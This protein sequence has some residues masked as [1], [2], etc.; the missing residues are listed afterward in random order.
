MA[1]V[2][3]KPGLY[4]Q[5]Y[6]L[7]LE[8]QAR[9][10][11]AGRLEDADLENIAEELEDMGRSQQRELRSRLRV[12]IA[13][14]LK[15][16]RQPDRRARSWERTILTQRQEIHDLLAQSPSLRRT[17]DLAANEAYP[18]AVKLAALDTGRSARTFPPELPYDLAR[19]LG[20]DEEAP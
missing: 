4:E 10:L 7:W 1:K 20:A 18:A 14:L 2:L 9:L 6:A 17:L 15:R 19:I 13:H 16:D 12:L 8:E 5:D 3:S 11:R